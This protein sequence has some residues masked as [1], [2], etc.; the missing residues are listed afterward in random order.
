MCSG[1]DGILVALAEDGHVCS[2]YLG[3]DPEVYESKATVAVTRKFN[4]EEIK[5]ETSRLAEIIKQAEQGAT[6]E[7]SGA[8]PADSPGI[9]VTVGQFSD[10]TFA[11]DPR[12]ATNQRTPVSKTQ[13]TIEPMTSSVLDVQIDVQLV[14]PLV[15][16]LTSC[17]VEELGEY[18]LSSF[19]HVLVTVTFHQGR[20]A[21]LG[22]IHFCFISS[23]LCVPFSARQHNIAYRAP[24]KQLGHGKKFEKNVLMGL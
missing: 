17:V 1:T 22:N 6:T 4:E 5:L 3:T 2:Y 14:E 24:L 8:R 21:A 16:V 20:D 13:M 11:F 9:R 15:A 10:I 23:T 19:A 18:L 7:N 12:N